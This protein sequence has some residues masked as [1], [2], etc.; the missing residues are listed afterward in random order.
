MDLINNTYQPYRKPH[1]ETVYINKNSNHPPN[2]SKRLA[3]AINT[4]IRDISCNQNIFD[5]AKTTY[6]QALRSNGFNEELKY[7]NKDGEE[8]TRNE[9]KWK[10]RMKI[11]PPFSLSVKTNIRKL[12]FKVLKNTSLKQTHYHKYL[13]RILKKLAIVAKET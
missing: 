2:I 10:R 6:E 11:N 9:E 7:K 13:M 12:F 8:Q 3:K 5:A 4:R 1:S